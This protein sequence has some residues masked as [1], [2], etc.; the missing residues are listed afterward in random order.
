MGF[1]ARVRMSWP[2]TA[3]GHTRHQQNSRP[4][5]ELGRVVQ[6]SR[7]AEGLVAVAPGTAHTKPSNS[8]V[9][10]SQGGT[11]GTKD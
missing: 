5:A 7:S 8:G 1:A 9:Q 4:V 11:R 6:H 3:R 10:A 2:R